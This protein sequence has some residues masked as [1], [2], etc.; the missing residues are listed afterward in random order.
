MAISKREQRLTSHIRATYPDTV[1]SYLGKEHFWALGEEVG[2]KK[3]SSG[4]LFT[5]LCFPIKGNVRLHKY[6]RPAPVD[7]DE[8]GLDIKTRRDIGMAMPPVRLSTCYPPLAL[9]LRG[10]NPMSKSQANYLVTSTVVQ[11]QGLIELGN[12]PEDAVS[13]F[14][15]K[16]LEN[17]S[18]LMPR[19]LELR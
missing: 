5:E 18:K 1:E 4:E 19:L 17:F 7:P 14:T 8:I 15:P 2:L 16:T 10:V 11:V 6:E 3:F 12:A 9:I 13:D